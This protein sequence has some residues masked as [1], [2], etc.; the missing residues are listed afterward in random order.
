MYFSAQLVL[1]LGYNVPCSF[2]FSVVVQCSCDTGVQIVELVLTT[3]RFLYIYAYNLSW[4]SET[5]KLC[6]VF[7]VLPEL[8]TRVRY[9]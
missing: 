2:Q 8:I 3:Q 7:Q 5:N 6:R 1:A 4:G 9:H